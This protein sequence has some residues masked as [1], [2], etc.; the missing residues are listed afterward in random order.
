[1]AFASLS[2]CGV[3]AIRNAVNGRVYVGSAVAV[4]KRYALHRHQ[5]KAGTHH[6]RKLQRAWDKYGA[7][8]FSV[9]VLETAPRERLVAIEQMWIDRLDAYKIGYNG[10]PTAASQLGLKFGAESR[11]KLSAATKAYMSRPGVSELLSERMTG[12]WANQTHRDSF[13][14]GAKRRAAMDGESARRSRAQKEWFAARPHERV[15]KAR[16][17]AKLTDEEVLLARTMRQGGA[18][19]RELCEKFVI[20][21]GPMSMLCRGITYRHVPMPGI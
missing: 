18:S 19:L 5:L 16:A 11:A 14:A 1:M 3:Y 15:K 9:E 12:I 8:A 2:V 13:V 4:D 20:C 21:K 7:S 17:L 6:S 10:R